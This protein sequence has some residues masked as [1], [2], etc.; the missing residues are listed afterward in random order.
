MKLWIYLTILMEITSLAHYVT[1]VDNC[2]SHALM[3][4]GISPS[5]AAKYSQVASEFNVPPQSLLQADDL[6]LRGLTVSADDRVRIANCQASYWASQ[7]T[8]LSRCHLEK[9]CNGR[10]ECVINLIQKSYLCKCQSGYIGNHCEAILNNC[11]SNPCSP[12]GVCQNAFQNFTCHCKVG[13][14]GRLCK[15]KWLTKN[16][17]RSRLQ[18]LTNDIKGT[19]VNSDY[20]L[21][22]L[23][24]QQSIIIRRLQLS[25]A[26]L[27]RSRL[28]RYRVFTDSLNAFSAAYQCSLYGGGLAMVKNT[29]DQKEIYNLAIRYRLQRIWLGAGDQLT[30]GYWYWWDRSPL[31]FKNFIPN[32]PNDSKG[33]EDCLEMLVVTANIRGGWNDVNCNVSLPFVCQFY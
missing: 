33:V 2:L 28:P 14:R 32:E 26:E 9:L 4:A 22:D 5:Q 12:G 11:I 27:K 29:E 8:N 20:S 10:G 17:T 19:I 25:I 7:T 23:I 31:I 18:Q 13:Y 3:L 30:E 1:A 21:L 15:E 6:F 24:D 16:G